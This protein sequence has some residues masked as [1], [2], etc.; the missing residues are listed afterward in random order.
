MLDGAGAA[1]FFAFGFFCAGSEPDGEYTTTAG[2]AATWIGLTAVG[3]AVFV[4][5]PLAF[6]MPNA[7]PNATTAAATPMATSFPGVISTSS[8]ACWS[9]DWCT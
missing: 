4:V 9:W 7:A 6:A 2:A 8:L 3:A 5:P 1:F